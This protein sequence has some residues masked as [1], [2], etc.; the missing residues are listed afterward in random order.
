MQLRENENVKKQIMQLSL[1]RIAKESKEYKSMGNQF[2]YN[3][4]SGTKTFE[5]LIGKNVFIFSEWKCL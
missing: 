5:Q 2:N 4:T 3:I 1:S